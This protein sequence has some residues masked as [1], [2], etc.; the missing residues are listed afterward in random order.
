MADPAQSAAGSDDGQ[1]RFLT[2]RCETTLYALP[3]E[4]VAEVVRTPLY[5]RVPHSPRGLLGIANLRGSVLPVASLG[6]LLGLGTGEIGHAS[7]TIVLSGS[8]PVAFVVDSVDALV[9][10]GTQHVE[11][12]QATIAAEPGERLRGAFH[13]GTDRTVAKIL[14]IQGLLATAF[15]PRAHP[16]GHAPMATRQDARH[17]IANAAADFHKLVSFEVAGQ[18]Y[19]LD[20]DAVLEIVTVPAGRVIVPGSE[21]L[22]LGVTRYR[23]TLLPLFSLRGLLG[24][25]AAQAWQDTAKIVVV[26]V[27]GALVGLVVDRMRAIMPAD[28]D[29]IEPTPSALAARIGGEARIRAIYRGSAGQQLV[30]ILAPDMLFRGEI[31]ERLMQGRDADQV[32]GGAE[33]HRADEAVTFLIFRLGGDEFG[34]PIG[35]V[36][37]VTRMPTQI[38]KVPNTPAFLE[39]VFNLRGQVVPVVDQRLR[40]GMAPL[41]DGSRRRLVVVR[42]AHHRAGLIVDGVTEVMRTDTDAIADAPNLTGEATRLVN[43]IVNLE[44]AGR[45]V[46]ILDPAELLTRAEQGLLDAFQVETEQAGL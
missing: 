43:G 28:P 13:T 44:Q 27:R 41:Q 22:A 5:A 46:L 10:I 18:D 19:A 17:D 34:L 2:F 21:S 15:A 20:L 12:T 9:S 1:Q 30:S 45:I 7:R 4:E 38:T 23:D 42:T 36:D 26:M 31:M 24:L 29:L 40:F 3:V 37:E 14:D 33:K 8:V 25:P 6:G 39:G 32:G 35:V 16:A 11:T